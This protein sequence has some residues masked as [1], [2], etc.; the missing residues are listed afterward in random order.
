MKTK[1][2]IEQ[3]INALVIEG[4]KSSGMGW[5]KPWRNAKG[6]LDCPVNWENGRAYRGVNEWILNFEMLI[7][8]YSHNQW[9]TAKMGYA[10]GGSNKG[11][12]G[13]AIIYWQIG[14]KVMNKGVAKYFNDLAPASKYAKSVGSKVE[15]SFTLR[16][17]TVFNIAQFEGLDPKGA[18]TPTPEIEA[19]TPIERAEAVIRDWQNAPSIQHKRGQA[20]YSPSLDIINMPKPETFIDPDSYYKTLFHEAVHATGHPS[21]LNRFEGDAKN[22]AFG[23]QEYSREELTAEIGSMYLT[24]FVDIHPKDSED[25]SVAYINGWVRHLTDHPSECLSAMG[26]ASK[27]VSLILNQTT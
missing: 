19:F 20:Y 2:D 22:A 23:S 5:F 24:G 1:I 8:G 25:N 26:R 21:R 3:S 15:K 27:A 10:K 9:L 13:T 6:D 4:L 14:Y 12:K 17:Y 18:D 7:K 16:E 11:E